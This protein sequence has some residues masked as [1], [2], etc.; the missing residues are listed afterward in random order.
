MKLKDKKKSE[1]RNQVS[2][3]TQKYSIT[4]MLGLLSVLNLENVCPY[5]FQNEM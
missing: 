5:V 2:K 1:L 3:M 4:W